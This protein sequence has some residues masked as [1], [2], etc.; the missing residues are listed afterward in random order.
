MNSASAG[1]TQAVGGTGSHET[2]DET[3]YKEMDDV[4]APL[5][6]AH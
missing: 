2:A 6:K 3:Y 4:M 5:P 1:I